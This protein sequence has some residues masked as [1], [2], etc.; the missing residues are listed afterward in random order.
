MQS[1]SPTHATL[2]ADCFLLAAPGVR[3]NTSTGSSAGKII[4]SEQA[5]IAPLQLASSLSSLPSPPPSPL[6]AGLPQHSPPLPT[7]GAVMQNSKYADA[8]PAAPRGMPQQSFSSAPRNSAGTAPPS[9]S[10]AWASQDVRG[11]LAVQPVTSAS[12]VKLKKNAVKIVGP[13]EPIATR[14]ATSMSP[15]VLSPT[16]KP[17]RIETET[18]NV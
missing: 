13:A 16:S 1:L 10:N 9:A 18:T 12:A 15:A 17:I 7:L 11:N 4:V 5:S 6:R 14:S 3:N 8:P 2:T